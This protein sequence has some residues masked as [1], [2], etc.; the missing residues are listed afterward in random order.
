VRDPRLAIVEREPVVRVD[1]DRHA[2]EPG[3]GA[4]EDS[5]LARVGVDDPGLLPLEEPLQLEEGDPVQ[6]GPRVAT[7]RIQ[8][9]DRNAQ[10]ARVL[11]EASLGALFR[12]RDERDVV[13]A[14][15]EPVAGEDRVFLRA[16]D[17]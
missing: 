16:A 17:G 5:R 2:R 12:P 10:S 8:D 1:D 6:D 3:R 13:P 4:A 15:D 11:E 9:D 7:Q 14:L